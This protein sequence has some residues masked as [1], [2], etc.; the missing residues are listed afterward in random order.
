MFA[1]QNICMYVDK[2]VNNKAYIPVSYMSFVTNHNLIAL[3]TC[4]LLNSEKYGMDT[5]ITKHHSFNILPSGTGTDV[6]ITSK[7]HP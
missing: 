4:A 2:I 5:E 6:W 7:S 3:V 1:L